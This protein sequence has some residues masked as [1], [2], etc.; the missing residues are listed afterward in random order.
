MPP[1]NPT[2]RVLSAL[3]QELA[4]RAA[5]RQG[6]P[7]L[8]GFSGGADSTALLLGLQQA[9]AAP[10]AVHLHH[11]LRG[12]AAD[13]DA[14]WCRAFADAHAL[15]FRQAALD[16]RTA[17]HRGESL[18]AAARRLRLDYWRRATAAAPGTV[19][20]LA[21][22]LD[23]A[24]E[25]LLL[26]LLR[27]GN[28]SALCGLRAWRQVGGVTL[29]RPLLSLRR[30][31]LEAY[32]RAQGVHDWRH[33]ASNDDR[34]LRRNRVRHEVLPLLRAVAGNDL[35]LTRSL[36]ALGD[37]AATLEAAAAAAA[38]TPR[39]VA[40][41]RALPPALWPRVLPAWLPPRAGADWQPRGAA[42]R[43]LAAA[44][45]APT[46][47]TATRLVELDGGWRLRLERGLVTVLPAASEGATDAD[48]AT[49]SPCTW[50]W[51]RQ[52]RLLLPAL[53]RQLSR[54]AV[55]G[56]PDAATAADPWRARWPR[57]A[58]PAVLTVRPRAPGDLLVPFGGAQPVRV[59]KLLGNARLS[60]AARAQVV[61]VT[62]A[63]G[64]LWWVP[65]VR[66]AAGATV[67]PGEAAVELFF[68]PLPVSSR[69]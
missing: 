16:V 21:H 47:L 69:T 19:V 18:E 66:R 51:A 56:P 48:T 42:L 54:R 45:A 41:L 13:A 43:R 9:G 60:T 3:R 35:G 67:A 28:A 25:T 40:A 12:A 33:D 4:A 44:V 5:A 62:D 68:G 36:A 61:V 34:D 38:A 26:R 6:A 27:G 57:T 1:A 37:D 8:V 10:V 53:D 32:L 63:A 29:W 65:G 58:L 46:A 14:A 52:A 50:R 59:K 24:L 55:V 15:L 7:L 49:W 2:R 23:D 39:T 11:G 30:A 20:A 31:E 64:T 17:R 22:H